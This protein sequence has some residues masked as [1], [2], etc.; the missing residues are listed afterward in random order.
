MR[1]MVLMA[2]CISLLTVQV[3]N[4][5]D[6]KAH[7]GKSYPYGYTNKQVKGYSRKHKGYA[8]PTSVKAHYRKQANKP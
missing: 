7:A 4:A 8:T 2:A 1:T 3:A 5:K 6:S